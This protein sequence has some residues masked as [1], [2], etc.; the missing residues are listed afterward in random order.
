MPVCDYGCSECVGLDDRRK[1]IPFYHA[2]HAV[3][4]V[5][6]R[7][8]LA[9]IHVNLIAVPE[10]FIA[11]ILLQPPA[12]LLRQSNGRYRLLPYPVA[13]GAEYPLRRFCPEVNR[14]LVEEYLKQ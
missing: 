2:L 9:N 11:K 13:H 8:I 12:H 14:A 7:P 3:Y 5:A 6:G 4:H 10:E 1:V